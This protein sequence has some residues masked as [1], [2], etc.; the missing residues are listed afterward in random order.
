MK[1]SNFEEVGQMRMRSGI[2]MKMMRNELALCPDLVKI[3]DESD[4]EGD[5]QA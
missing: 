3:S 1:V 5:I 4:G 2:S